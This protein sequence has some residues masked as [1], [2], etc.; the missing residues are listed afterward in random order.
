MKTLRNFVIA[1]ALGATFGTASSALAEEPAYKA[2]DVVK[3]FSGQADL[4]VSRGICIGTA[5]D[6]GLK[7]ET[8]QNKSGFDLTVNFDFGSATLTDGAK[9]NLDA[10]A[11]ALKDDR[12]QRAKFVLEG[13]TD[14]VGSDAANR[15]LSE[16]RARS[17]AVYLVQKGVEVTKL[18]PVGYGEA[19]PLTNDPY[20]ATNRR[21]EARM[22][23]Q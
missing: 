9:R 7:A 6:C 23:V 10:F 22:V 17:V 21:V 3:F 19:K 2:D 13:H 15:Q 8:A 14:A 1:A 11:E 18:E 5:E 16:A 20:D 4:G 12:L